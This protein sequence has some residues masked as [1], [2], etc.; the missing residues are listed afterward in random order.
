M[1][2]S[3]QKHVLTSEIEKETGESNAAGL[4]PIR[5]KCMISVT[6]LVKKPYNVF[7]CKKL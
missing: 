5:K 7:Y 3:Y 6:V 1:M 2:T 4:I